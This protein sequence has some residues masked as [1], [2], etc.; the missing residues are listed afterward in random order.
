[1]TDDQLQATLRR[2]RAAYIAE[3]PSRVA[4]LEAQIERVERGDAAAISEL[5]RLFHRLAG[6]GGSYGLDDVTA[7]A[8]AGELMANDLAKRGGPVSPESIAALRTKTGAVAAAFE[9]ARG[10]DAPIE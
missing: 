6:S 5:S 7:A 10:T 9:A 1:M 8:R 3:G 4:D 2:L